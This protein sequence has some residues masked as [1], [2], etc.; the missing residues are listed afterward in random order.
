MGT[1]YNRWP[2]FPW[3]ELNAK[4]VKG[5]KEILNAWRRLAFPV[6]LLDGPIPCTTILFPPAVSVI[7]NECTRPLSDIAILVQL[8]H[9]VIG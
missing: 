2:I 4:V 9:S 6:I 5:D 1:V 3:P 7:Y 8:L